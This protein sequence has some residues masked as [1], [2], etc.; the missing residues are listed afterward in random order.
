MLTTK[1]IKDKAERNYKDF[2]LSLLKK[3]IFFPLDIKGNKGNANMP[4]QELYPALKHL[5]DN[6]K[7]KIG[8]GYTVQYKEVNTRHSGII[9][10]PDAI[11]FENP[12]D[13]LRFIDREKDFTAFRKAVDLTKKELPVLLKWIEGNV[14]KCQKY[15]DNWGDILAIVQYFIKNPK[16]NIYWRQLPLAIDVLAAELL[17]PIIGELLEY[18]LP[19]LYFDKNETHFEPR[20]GL[21]YDEHLVRI[22][23]LDEAITPLSISDD[24]TI[25]AS[26]FSKWVDIP[27]KKV[28]FVTDKNVFLGFPKHPLSIL[29]LLDTHFSFLHKIEW[30][31]DKTC[32]FTGDINPKGYEQLSEIRG[33][34]RGVKSLMMDKPTFDT[35]PQKQQFYNPEKTNAFLP[36]LTTEEQAFYTLLLHS[37]SKNGL[38]QRD[39][40]YPYLVKTFSQI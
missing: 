6:S 31:Q 33:I 22:Q 13:Y 3:E 8:Y 4:L 12:S 1:E 32:Y 18:V 26:N 9:T 23:F 25:P 29:I 7:E 24:F 39:I 38:L 27:C 40:S 19:P 34:L 15:A 2:L 17:Q 28:F 35:Y 16:S 5:I 14:L 11:L 36:H 10:L 30:L 20:F 37:D 21:K